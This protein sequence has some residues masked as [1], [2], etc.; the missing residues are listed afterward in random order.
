MH[1]ADIDQISNNGDSLLHRAGTVSKIAL[2]FFLLS[3]FII[4]NDFV[5]LGCL[6]VILFLLFILGRIPL[7]QV[8]HLAIYPAFFSTIFAFIS[9]QQSW[10]LGVIVIMKAVG[11]AFTMLLLITT[12]PYIDI[13]AFLSLFMSSLLVD[14]FMFTYR[15]FFILIHKIQNSMK[16]I[17]LRGGYRPFNLWM[18]LK[19][20]AGILGVLV[21]HSFEMSERMYKI[22]ALRGYKGGIPL[23]TEI[24]PLKAIDVGIIIFGIVILVGTVIPWK[25]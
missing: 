24:F 18:N 8:M 14:I 15:S 13:F 22:Y 21:I 7:K 25:I 19:S 5:R 17:R 6:M 20:A 23:N 4:S 2:T 3:S 16:S 9:A 11:S 10:K 1:L 12:T